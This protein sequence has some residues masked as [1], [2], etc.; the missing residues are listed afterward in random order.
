[1]INADQAGDANYYPALR[2]QQSF[3][4]GR[5]NQTISFT[6]TA[7][8]SAAVGGTTYTPTAAATSGLTVALTIDS[9]ASSVCSLSAGVVSFTT[10]GACV[11]NAD[12]AGDANYYP[13]LRVQQSFQVGQSKTATPSA[14]THLVISEFRT[15]GPNGLED[16][17]VELYNPSGAAVNIGGWMIRKSSSCGTTLAT[18]VTIPANTILLAGQHY[19]VA[20]TTSSVT[21]A[22]QTFAASLADDGGLALVSALGTLVDQVGMC[23]T[24]QY[25]EGTTLLPLTGTSNQSYE[26]KPGGATSCY[27]TNK[28]ASDFALISP[29]SPLKKASPVVMCAGVLAYTPS[30]TPTRTP[31]RTPT[32]AATLIPGS[33]VINEFLPHPKTD[34]NGDGSANT[35]D[36]YIELI[37]MGTE[38]ASIKNWKLDNGVGTSAYT[39]PDVTL[40]PRQIV[41][42]YHSKS[43]IA[44]SDGGSTVR[45]L[46][47]NGRMADS[48]TYPVVA[49]ADQT[50]CRLPDGSGTWAFACLPT[51]G[52]LNS[53]NTTAIP[54][55]SASFP[56]EA[57]KP[58]SPAC[59]ID[60]APP[61]VLAAECNGH[62]A[63]IWNAVG[64]KEIWLESR[65]KWK[66]FVE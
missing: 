57:G 51:P 43:G 47:S 28:N 52:K 16:E 44:L 62:G 2:V 37:N 4:V 19:L 6:S 42:F 12:Q 48:Y 3:A 53:R 33:V 9:S 18:L 65:W 49:A 55:V 50:W 8:A 46:K 60:S 36:E 13:A 22:D 66:V 61:P 20:A 41:V 45:L 58:E 23:A 29:A 31:M 21:A 63:N 39:L 5:G 27:D 11:I 15:S 1:V 10:V 59:Y 34:W 38:S 30:S 25:R 56:K 35:G 14:P 24:T 54:T 7:P 32:R 40:L 26:R 64:S 17:F